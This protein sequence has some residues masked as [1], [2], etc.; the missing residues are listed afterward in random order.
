MQ[1]EKFGSP[2][3]S[4]KGNNASSSS[5][6]KDKQYLPSRYALDSTKQDSKVTN[7]LNSIPVLIQPSNS[8]LATIPSCSLL[9]QASLPSRRRHDPW[10]PR[11]R[12][13]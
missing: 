10:Q 6:V 5:L 2:K 8:I 1:E 12:R 13:L 3:V 4:K 9:P 11:R 7:L